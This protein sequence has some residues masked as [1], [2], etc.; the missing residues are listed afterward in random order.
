MSGTLHFDCPLND[1]NQH[2]SVLSLPQF[3]TDG[4]VETHR[5]NERAETYETQ[6]DRLQGSCTKIEFH[7][8]FARPSPLRTLYFAITSHINR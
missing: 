4:Q 2:S 3:L 8:V 6:T 7:L 5:M 1:F